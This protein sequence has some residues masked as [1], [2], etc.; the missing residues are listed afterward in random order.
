MIVRRTTGE[1]F[2]VKSFAS[3]ETVGKPDMNSLMVGALHKRVFRE[4]AKFSPSADYNFVRI[5]VLADG[6]CFWHCILR[7][8]LPQEYKSYK[9]VESGGPVSLERLEKEISLAKTTHQE[10]IHLYRDQPTFN[11]TIVK[12]LESSPQVH[13]QFAQT[14][15]QVSGI[16]LRISLSPEVR[17]Y[18]YEQLKGDF[19]PKS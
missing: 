6:Y 12:K 9:R 1:S 10:F 3:L 13:L 14:I 17:I 4:Q 15:C 8:S 18:K 16:S 19:E 2:V 11:K 7:V 5:P